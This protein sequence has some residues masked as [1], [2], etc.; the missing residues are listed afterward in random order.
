MFHPLGGDEFIGDFADH[1]RL[2]AYEQYFEAIVM[3]QMEQQSSDNK[4]QAIGSAAF[5]QLLGFR[6]HD[7][8]KFTIDDDLGWLVF[9]GCHKSLMKVKVKGSVPHF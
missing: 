4:T 9:V 2:A 3:V 8:I 5:P 7:K 1:P 6:S